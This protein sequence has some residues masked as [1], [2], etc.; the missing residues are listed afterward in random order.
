MYRFV[1]SKLDHHIN[2]AGYYTNWCTTIWCRCNI[3][4]TN[5]CNDIGSCY[6]INGNGTWNTNSSSLNGRCAV[7]LK[8]TAIP[9]KRKNLNFFLYAVK[10]N[11]V[12]NMSVKYL[13]CSMY[14]K[15]V[16]GREE[17]REMGC[18][19][20]LF[21]RSLWITCFLWRKKVKVFDDYSSYFPI[22]HVSS[23]FHFNRT[24]KK[25]ENNLGVRSP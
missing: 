20:S 5:G 18:T 6:V 16:N 22:L 14:V 9:K 21:S 1:Q 10:H 25:E 17:W 23:N 7:D 15:W 13:S 3:H 4:Q 12:M 8:G 2:R 24:N 19:D 11:Y